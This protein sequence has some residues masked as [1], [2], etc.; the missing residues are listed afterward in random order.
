MV[1]EKEIFE[2][3]CRRVA[4]VIAIQAIAHNSL[5]DSPYEKFMDFSV[6]DGPR[7]VSEK[8]CEILLETYGF[9]SVINEEKPQLRIRVLFGKCTEEA[10]AAP[11]NALHPDKI[12]SMI[13]PVSAAPSSP[14]ST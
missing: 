1:D 2:A 7:F 13:N 5:P 8:I 10:V 4:G 6:I 9:R 11:I 14:A 3:E 12:T